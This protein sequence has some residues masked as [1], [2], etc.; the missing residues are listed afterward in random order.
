MRHS[1]ISKVA[2]AMLAVSTLSACGGRFGYTD[3]TPSTLVSVRSPIT[4]INDTRYRSPAVSN[5]P[6]TV[7]SSSL[8]STNAQ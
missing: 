4:I 8:E 1:S 5:I 3:A 6:T 2:L 7:P